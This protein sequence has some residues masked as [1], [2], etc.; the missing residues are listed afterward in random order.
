MHKQLRFTEQIA[1]MIDPLERAVTAQAML[2]EQRPVTNRLVAIRRQ[3]VAEASRRPGVTYDLIAERLGISKAMV[4]RLVS[5]TL[6][7]M[8]PGGLDSPFDFE[9]NLRT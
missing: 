3:A 5:E 4:G 6:R 2:D 8:L 1:K 9:G 7:D